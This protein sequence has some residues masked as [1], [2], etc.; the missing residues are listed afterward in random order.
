MVP[1]AP[2]KNAL[3][4]F[5]NDS[6]SS[7]NGLSIMLQCT[8]IQHKE[9]KFKGVVYPYTHPCGQCIACRIRSQ[10]GWVTRLFFE[11][12]YNPIGAIFITPTYAPEN[13]PLTP[14]G[15]PTLV[16][17]EISKFIKRLRANTGLRICYFGSG[18]MGE[19]FGRPHYHI[20]IFGLNYLSYRP[21]KHL[22]LPSSIKELFKSRKVPY[23]GLSQLQ[24]ELLKAWQYKGTIDIKPFN[25]GSALY[26][27]KYIL[28]KT[29]SEEDYL[30]GQY[31]EHQRQ[32]TRPAIGYVAVKPLAAKLIQLKRYPV[33]CS[34]LA[35]DSSWQPD[36]FNHVHFRSDNRK[37]WLP[38]PQGFRD[39]VIKEMESLLSSSDD[40]SEKLKAILATMESRRPAVKNDA[41]IQ[42]HIDQY[43]D[44]Q[45]N[46]L[47]IEFFE[48]ESQKDSAIINKIKRSY[49][50]VNR[51]SNF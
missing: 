3:P 19:R 10:L 11:F 40:K 1:I 15:D 26:I 5:V 25:I 21:K 46:D 18:E 32:S 7:K 35:E 24:L 30:P 42:L 14:D 29:L 16:K 50:E 43:G 36:L 13:L 20:I 45:G 22:S 47:A 49:G 12:K 37:K 38:I 44:E 28:K 4:A 33:E 51:R 34:Y 39:A 8:D 6:R 2:S 9:R 31:P 17:D 23:I 27:V 48:R 41:I